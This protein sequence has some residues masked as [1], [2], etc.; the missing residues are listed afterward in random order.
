MILLVEISWFV[1]RSDH[2]DATIRRKPT[3]NNNV[4]ATLQLTKEL[5]SASS[6]DLPVHFCQQLVDGLV[7]IWMHGATRA[8]PSNTVDFIK[9]DHARRNLLCFL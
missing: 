3:G 1:C 8:F 6:F 5:F 9:E 4:L 2:N 7:R